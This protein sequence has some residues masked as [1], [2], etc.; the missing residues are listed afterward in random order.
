MAPVQV[1][2]PRKDL[3][4]GDAVHAVVDPREPQRAALDG[5]GWPW[6]QVL[7]PLAG[8][9]LVVAYGVKFG[10]WPRAEPLGI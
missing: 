10:R 6:R 5:D 8:L 4:V 2:T 3:Q 9:P 1:A 7:I